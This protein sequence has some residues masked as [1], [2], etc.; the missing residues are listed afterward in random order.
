VALRRGTRE[1]CDDRDDF[2]S[3]SFFEANLK[4]LFVR[5]SIWRRATA[6]FDILP[7]LFAQYGACQGRSVKQTHL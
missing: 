3:L 4:L 5:R 1:S 2:A 7:A 6:E